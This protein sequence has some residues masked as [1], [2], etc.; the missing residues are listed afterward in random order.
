MLLIVKIIF[1]Y[2]FIKQEEAATMV[3]LRN[4]K[5]LRIIDT[6]FPIVVRSVIKI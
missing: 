6:Y 1:C 2:E 3:E 4:T 5:K